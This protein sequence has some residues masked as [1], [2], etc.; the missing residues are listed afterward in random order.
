VEAKHCIT[1]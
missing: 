1:K